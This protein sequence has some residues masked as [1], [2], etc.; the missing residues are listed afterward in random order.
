MNFTTDKELNNLTNG[1]PFYVIIY[2]SYKLL[3]TVSFLDHPV[4]TVTLHQL[5]QLHGEAQT[6]TRPPGF[7]W[8]NFVNIR[9]SYMKISGNIAEGMLSMHI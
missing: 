2:R 8:H 3:K 7:K 5:Q 4:L 1:L 9:F 6:I